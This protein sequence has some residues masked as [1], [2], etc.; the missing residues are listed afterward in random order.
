[1]VNVKG[2]KCV[3][4]PLNF[5]FTTS[6]HMYKP[7]NI[8]ECCFSGQKIIA[9]IYLGLQFEMEMSKIAGYDVLNS[10]KIK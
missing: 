8:A 5:A 1:M 7:E 4:E 10:I 9:F 6:K 2:S 3:L